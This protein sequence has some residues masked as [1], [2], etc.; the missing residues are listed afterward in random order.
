[1]LSL[2]CLKFELHNNNRV[3]ENLTYLILDPDTSML[4]AYIERDAE[5]GH[6]MCKTCGKTNLKKWCIKSHIEAIHFAG[7]FVYNCQICGK[8]FNSKNSLSTHTFRSHRPDP[9]VF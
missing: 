9:Q 5:T 7:Q 6:W 3:L 4:E 1:M 2:Q 8:T